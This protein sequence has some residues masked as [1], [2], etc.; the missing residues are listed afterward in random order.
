MKIYTKIALSRSKFGDTKKHFERGHGIAIE[1]ESK[2]P[3][4]CT[5]VSRRSLFLYK[6]KPILGYL[7]DYVRIDIMLVF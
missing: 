1:V 5:K 4:E 2:R 3:N 6:H 7:Y